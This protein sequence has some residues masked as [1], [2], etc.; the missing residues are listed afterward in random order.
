MSVKALDGNQVC[1]IAQLYSDGLSSVKIARQFGVSSR[2]I[3]NYLL[4]E[5]IALRPGGVSPFWTRERKEEAARRYCAGESQAEIADSWKISQH[6][7]SVVLRSLGISTRKPQWRDGNPNWKGGR[8]IDEQGYV[9]V[10]PSDQDLELG[11]L[12]STGYVPEHR[13]VMARKLGRPL[14]RNET[15]H[16]INGDK[17]DNRP[18]NLQLRQGGHGKGVVLC[19]MECGSRKV[20]AIPLE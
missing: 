13:L 12:L 10:K 11:S 6:G 16:H 19:C 3:R 1:E 17:Q 7:V 5:G 15:V 18:E 14:R 20:E 4:R 8:Y 9:Q 2:T